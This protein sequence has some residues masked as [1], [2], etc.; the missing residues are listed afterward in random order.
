MTSPQADGD[1]G[2]EPTKDPL[3][4]DNLPPDER[5]AL[6]SAALLRD[7][8]A[9]ARAAGTSRRLIDSRRVAVMLRETAALLVSAAELLE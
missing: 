6:V 2:A 8:M 4:M 9:A 3:D 5:D 7:R 1:H